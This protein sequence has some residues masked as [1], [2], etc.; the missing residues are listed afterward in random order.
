MKTF[1]FKIL[2]VVTVGL[3]MYVSVLVLDKNTTINTE[4]IDTINRKMNS[5]E[6]TII[7][8]EEELKNLKIIYRGLRDA[9]N[10]TEIEVDTKVRQAVD[11][12][13]REQ[14]ATGGLGVLT[15]D[16]AELEKVE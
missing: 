14:S 15:G 11:D 2:I 10:N 7:E 5:L 12:K 4:D 8:V 13:F 9:V 3:T 1:M 6:E 16:Y